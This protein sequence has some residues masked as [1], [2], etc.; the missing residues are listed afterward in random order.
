MVQSGQCP[1][2]K[3]DKIVY[4]LSLKYGNID[5]ILTNKINIHNKNIYFTD[6]IIKTQYSDLNEISYLSTKC[7]IIVGRA[8]GPHAFTHVKENYN[9]NSKTFISFT[10]KILE[11]NWYNSNLCNQVWSNIYSEKSIFDILNKEIE[12]YAR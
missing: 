10:D 9:D 4:D 2:F 5:F 1:N 11:G 7:D 3:F 8:S 6:D 12:N